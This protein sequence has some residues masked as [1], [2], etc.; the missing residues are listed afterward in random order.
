MVE[1]VGGVLMVVRQFWMLRGI[2]LV[3]PSLLSWLFVG[4][5]DSG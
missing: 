1:Q 2:V 4:K 5:C 3:G